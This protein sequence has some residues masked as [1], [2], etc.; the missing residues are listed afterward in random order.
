MREEKIELRKGIQL[1]ADE[2]DDYLVKGN[3]SS[4]VYMK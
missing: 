2:E 4:E 1:I 3:E